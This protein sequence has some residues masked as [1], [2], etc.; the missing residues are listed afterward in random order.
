MFPSKHGRLRVTAWSLIYYTVMKEYAKTFY[1]S[2]AWKDCRKAY[3]AYRRGL[4]EVC[5]KRGIY[6]PGEIVHHKIHISPENITDPT[7]TLSFDNLQL[8]CRDCHADLH[9]GFETRYKVD[10]LGR[11]T[12]V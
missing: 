5:L 2:A 12:A 4:C 10:E 11:I 9:K 1:K 3:A 8:V 7:V 6:K